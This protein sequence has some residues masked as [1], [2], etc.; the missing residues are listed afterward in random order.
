M[1]GELALAMECSPVQLATMDSSA[2]ILQRHH[3]PSEGWFDPNRNSQR[4][5]ICEHALQRSNV[6]KTINTPELIFNR[7]NQDRISFFEKYFLM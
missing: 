4:S 6:T 1:V 3:V 5:R 7:P 2:C